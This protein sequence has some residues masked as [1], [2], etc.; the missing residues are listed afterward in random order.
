MIDKSLETGSSAQVRIWVD[1]L[2]IPGKKQTRLIPGSVATV[3]VP[4]AEKK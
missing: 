4:P 1:V 3:V 2:T